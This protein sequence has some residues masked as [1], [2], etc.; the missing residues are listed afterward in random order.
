MNRVLRIDD[1]GW[2]WEI[3]IAVIARHYASRV[4]RDDRNTSYEVEYEFIASDKHGLYEA[5]DW[6]QTNMSWI[7]VAGAAKLIR[8]PAAKSEPGIN[9]IVT[10]VDLPP[11]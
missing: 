11:R 10:A 7:D 3:P 2:R 4:S 1:D 8:R 6:Y 9:A 5:A